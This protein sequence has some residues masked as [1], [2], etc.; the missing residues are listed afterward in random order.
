[1]ILADDSQ[2][3]S[4]ITLTLWEKM[5]VEFNHNGRVIAIKGFKV[6]EWNQVK[7]LS[8]GFYYEVEPDNARVEDL[9]AWSNTLKADQLSQAPTQLI[10]TSFGPVEELTTEWVRLHKG[11][12]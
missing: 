1:M 9:I 6:G 4:S 2:G 3:G 7:N 5:A 8:L 11:C 12:Q 10:N